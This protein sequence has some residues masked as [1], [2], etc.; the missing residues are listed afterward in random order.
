MFEKNKK[1]QLEFFP[2][3]TIQKEKSFN[4]VYLNISQ[5][6]Q[7]ATSLKLGLQKSSKEMVCG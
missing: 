4:E 5:V 7:S 3:A 6:R 1:N 2:R